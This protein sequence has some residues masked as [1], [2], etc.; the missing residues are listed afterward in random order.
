MGRMRVKGR[1]LKPWIFGIIAGVIVVVPGFF[2]PVRIPAS[3]NF[4]LSCHT[5]DL[6]NGIINWFSGTYLPQ[7]FISRKLL[8]VTSPAVIAGAFVAAR[9]YSEKR[10]IKAEKPIQSF[11]IGS[12]VMLI[13]IV[14]YGCPTRLIIRAG[15]GEVYAIFAVTAMILGV[16]TA[17]FIVRLR[18]KISR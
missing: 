5:H 12:L 6:I 15:F 8:L 3:Y 11:L 14:I 2:L 1:Y 13:G 17:S 10:R 9:M 7:T 16:V 18:W 4:C